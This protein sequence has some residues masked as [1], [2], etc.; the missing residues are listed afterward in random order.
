MD[1]LNY[2]IMSGIGLGKLSRLLNVV[3]MSVFAQVCLSQNLVEIKSKDIDKELLEILET[4]VK[5]HPTTQSFLLT[6]DANFNYDWPWNLYFAHILIIGPFLNGTI[7]QP[8][9]TCD[10]DAE[11]MQ[12]IFEGIS[13]V[14]KNPTAYFYI[15]DKIVYI[16]SSLD[17]MIDADKSDMS[18]DK[19]SDNNPIMKYMDEADIITVKY[20]VYPSYTLHNDYRNALKKSRIHAEEFWKINEINDYE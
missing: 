2:I 14:T 20:N 4:H 11:I 9:K 12:N 8:D 17:K 16:Q 6:S 13:P 7:N 5:N 15:N 10:Y 3:L 18:F 1:N 19:K